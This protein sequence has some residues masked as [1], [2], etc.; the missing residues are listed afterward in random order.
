MT[1]ATK[2]VSR[3]VRRDML[4][5]LARDGRLVCVKSYHFDDMTG[6]DRTCKEMPVAIHE[7]GTPANYREG[8]CTLRPD[9]FEGKPGHATRREDG[10]IW[11]YIHSNLNY[12]F[13]VLPEKTG[14]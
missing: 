5:R 2:P 1:T 4:L 8:V 3:T 13:R 14:A 12:T 11:L 7:P 9:H 10:T 6:T